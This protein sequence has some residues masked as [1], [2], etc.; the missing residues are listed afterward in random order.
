MSERVLYL[1]ICAAG[2]AD[3]V[4]TMVQLAQRDGWSV[5]CIATPAAVEHFLDWPGSK[6]PAVT[7]YARPTGNGEI[8]PS[9][10]RM[11]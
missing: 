9:P 6:P 7:R 10:E 8:Y 2:P 3:R 1:V 5:Y 4:E 11:P